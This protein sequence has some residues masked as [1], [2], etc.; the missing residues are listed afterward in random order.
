MTKTDYEISPGFQ[1]DFKKLSKRFRTLPQDLET[2]K[3]NAIELFHIRGIDN[4][5]IFFI[6]HFC[7]EKIKICK[8]KKFASRSLKGRGVQSGIRIIYAFFGRQPMKV[9]FLEIYFKGDKKREDF[10]RIKQYLKSL[11]G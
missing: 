7:S 9:V 1:K 6:P 3:V 2:A 5:S 11:A 4:R 8:L 10:D